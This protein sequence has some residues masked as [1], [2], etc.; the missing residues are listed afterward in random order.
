[1]AEECGAE[2]RAHAKG[3]LMCTEAGSPVTQGRSLREGSKMTGD[4]SDRGVATGEGFYH[5]CL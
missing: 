4:R 1:M 2:A 3:L 5:N